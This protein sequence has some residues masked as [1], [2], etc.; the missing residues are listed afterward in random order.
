MI[1]LC[2][3]QQQYNT[4]DSLVC[5]ETLGTFVCMHGT[6]YVYNIY[7]YVYTSTTSLRLYKNSGTQNLIQPA[8]KWSFTSSPPLRPAPPLLAE[9]PAWRSKSR[10]SNSKRTSNAA[11]RTSGVLSISMADTMSTWC[12]QWMGTNVEVQAMHSPEGVDPNLSIASQGHHL[13]VPSV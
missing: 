11:I 12:T 3:S 4:K 13:E 9:A 6:I 2:H 5:S 1:A 8:Q 7:I 10:T